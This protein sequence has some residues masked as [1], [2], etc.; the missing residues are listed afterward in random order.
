M[1]T[2]DIQDWEGTELIQEFVDYVVTGVAEAKAT[3]SRW[4]GAMVDSITV[5]STSDG[6]LIYIDRSSVR[7]KSGRKNYYPYRYAYKGYGNAHPPFDFIYEALMNVGDN[8]IGDRTTW[9]A[10]KPSGRRG[11]GS[12]VL[13][14]RNTFAPQNYL[15]RKKNTYKVNIPNSLRK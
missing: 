10:I 8:N 3:G 14:H 11:T 13:S 6:F 4:T 12:S 5:D 15:R 2:I 7:A 1:T 9:Q